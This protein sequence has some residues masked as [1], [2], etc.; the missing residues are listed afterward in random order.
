[1]QESSGLKP[2]Q[3]GTNGL[4]GAKQCKT[5]YGFNILWI[6]TTKLFKIFSLRNRVKSQ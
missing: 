1:M 5:Y 3:A 6:M 2:D 4:F